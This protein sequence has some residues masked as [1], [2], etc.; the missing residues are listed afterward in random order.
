MDKYNWRFP[1]LDNGPEQGINDGGIA[2]F[3]GSKLYTYLAREICQNSLD[4]KAEGKKTV[5]V[6]FNSLSLKK[7][8][9]PSLSELENIFSN[10][11]DYWNKR[12]EPKLKRF[13]DE[14]EKEISKDEINLLVIRDFNTTGLSG[15][16]AGRGE[17]SKWRALTHSNGVTEKAKGSQGSYG[18]GKNAPFACSSLRTVFYNSYAEEDGEK[19]F[20]GVARLITHVQDGEETIGV[21]FYHNVEN[22][23]PIFSDDEC[24][25]RDLLNRQEFGT[26]VVIAGFKQTESWKEDIEKA[27]LSNFFVTIA[28]DD[29]VVRIDGLEINSGNLKDRIK[30]YA[31][32]EAQSNEK[33][34]NITPILEFY[35]AISEYD[36]KETGDIIENGDA[37]LY[38]KKDDGF[39]KSIAE[40]RSIGMVVR[41]R[42]NNIFTRYAAVVVVQSGELNDLL[43]EIEPPAHD[44]WDP[45]LIEDDPETQAKAR[46]YRSKLISW[47]NKVIAEKCRSEAT[48]EIDLD[49]MSAYLPFDDEDKA[50]SGTEPESDITPDGDTKMD[51]PVARK[52]NVKKLNVVAKK[53]KGYKDENSDPHNQ[54]GGGSSGGS[55]GTEDP[56][57]PDDVTA[58]VPGNKSV[59]IP[60]VLKQRVSKAPAE[61]QYR[62]VFMLEEDCPVVNLAL[63]AIGDDGNKEQLKIVDYKIDRSKVTANAQHI[64]VKD[65]KAKT[66]YEVFLNLEYAERM[67]LELLLY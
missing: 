58:P 47:V 67:Q 25:L 65:I 12:M 34:K 3:K 52:P 40:M 21:G 20:Q 63:K 33:E 37:I 42:H 49:G 44:D 15:A 27:V 45:G 1:R 6:E 62:V 9:Y 5:V 16:K 8:D 23:C 66:T 11:R 55:A 22:N 59:N 13:L 54:G 39:S 53:V 14:A 4:A 36:F 35:H 43:K 64:A 31:D 61:T 51:T 26:D 19:A 46:K 50:L 56:N 30:Y 38:I 28:N 18:I 32:K 29:L 10:C 60:R 41:T 48:D 57:G 7:A 24:A 17:K 2:T